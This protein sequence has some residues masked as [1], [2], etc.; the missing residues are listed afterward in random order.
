M[1]AEKCISAVEVSVKLAHNSNFTYCKACKANS[2][3]VV[4]ASLKATH[5]QNTRSSSGSG[6]PKVKAFLERS[7]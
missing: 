6:R 7:T 5:W 2:S 1:L 3:R 4:S